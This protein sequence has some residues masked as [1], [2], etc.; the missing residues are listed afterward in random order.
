MQNKIKAIKISIGRWILFNLT[1]H[2][3]IGEERPYQYQTREEA[4]KAAEK[5]W[6]YNSTWKG[7]RVHG[8]YN[9]TV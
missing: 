7:H 4:Y 8:G 3:P 2:E 1:T 6:L 9:I 5:M